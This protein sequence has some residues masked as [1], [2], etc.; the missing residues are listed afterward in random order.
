MKKKINHITFYSNKDTAKF[1]KK[2]ISDN[3]NYYI[4]KF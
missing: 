4:E 2:N 1:T 3:I